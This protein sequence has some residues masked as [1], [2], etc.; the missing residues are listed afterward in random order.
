MVHVYMY[1]ILHCVL[2]IVCLY[3]HIQYILYTYNVHVYVHVHDMYTYYTHHMHFCTQQFPLTN[4]PVRLVPQFVRKAGMSQQS[5]Q[6]HMLNGN[7][8]WLTQ[9]QNMS[10]IQQLIATCL[11]KINHLYMYM[12]MY[13]VHVCCNTPNPLRV[14]TMYMYMYMYMCVTKVPVLKAGHSSIVHA[15]VHVHVY[16]MCWFV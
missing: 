14:G 9:Y 16:C 2:H 8:C 7:L 6:E 4:K 10:Q 15:L 13:N 11:V 1:R 5:F 12:C 3:T